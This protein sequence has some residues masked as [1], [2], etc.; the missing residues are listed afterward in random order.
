MDRLVTETADQIKGRLSHPRVVLTLRSVP[1]VGI[2]ALAA[3]LLVH[4]LGSRSFWIDETVSVRA[5]ELGWANFFSFAWHEEVNMALY[6]FLLRFWVAFGDSEGTV[7]AFSVLAALLAVF[8]IYGLAQAL[9]DRRTALAAALLL[10][11]NSAY[12]TYGREARSYA[13]VLLLTTVS[14]YTF[15]RALRSPSPI[16]WSF[17]VVLTA[18]AV[19]SHLYA[20]LV[21]IAH[22]AS[23]VL[24]R[25][26]P[27]PWRQMAAA[28]AVL[29]VLLL[30]AA[31][32][33]A[34]AGQ[35]ARVPGWQADVKDIYLLF[36]WFTGH[37]RPL[38]LLYFLACSGAVLSALLAYARLGPGFEVWRIGFLVSGVVLPI[39]IAF[40]ISQVH[41]IFA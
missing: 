38:L 17:Y 37:N 32:Y 3:V 15:V 29:A 25:R 31:A 36:D 6:N 22:L 41:P 9:F 2:A 40:F 12:L 4:S 14:S 24:W 20:L 11:L 35:S 26:H 23:L 13:L 19:Y 16:R 10:G 7:R 34:F 18:S 28:A 5:S 1:L 27:I 33:V 8:A 30:P 39:A 21:P